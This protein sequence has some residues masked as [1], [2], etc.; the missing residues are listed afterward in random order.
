MKEDEKEEY[1]IREI[2]EI[3]NRL[4]QYYEPI[5][6]E[7]ENDLKEY[8]R[9]FDVPIEHLFPYRFNDPRKSKD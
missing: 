5:L 2:G 3:Q 6:K 8:I 4:L 9:L 1:D 7:M